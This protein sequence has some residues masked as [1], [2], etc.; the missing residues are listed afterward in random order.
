MIALTRE[1]TAGAIPVAFR[2]R[3]RVAQMRSLADVTAEGKREFKS[4]YWKKAKDQLK[5]ESHGKCA[6]CEASTATVAHG[7]V[8]HFRPKSVYWWLA[9]CY[10]NYLYACQIC[11][12]VYKGDRFPTRGTAMAAPLLPSPGLSDEQIDA[13]IATW[14][15]DPLNEADGLAWDAFSTHLKGEEAGLL[16]PYTDDPERYLAWESDP[17]NREVKLIPRDG[18]DLVH[19]YIAKCAEELYGLNREELR[20][21]RYATYDTLQVMVQAWQTGV[22]PEPLQASVAGQIGTMLSDKSEY[23]GMSR[24]FVRT[25]WG[26]GF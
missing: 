17:V 21:R 23:A 6:Y 2:G 25:V 26:L 10:D 4:T 12:Q 9:Y 14:S 15:P 5:R 16:C 13:I 20:L 8:E 1:R 7:D 3:K 11:N 18:A 19:V 22:L 24:Y